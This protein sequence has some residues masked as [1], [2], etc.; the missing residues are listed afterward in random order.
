PQSLSVLLL[1]FL[2]SCSS[3]LPASLPTL[4]PY[5]TLFRSLADLAEHVFGRH[6]DVLEDQ[7]RRRRAVQ[8][9]LV[10]F[11]A[12]LHAERALDEER[13]ELLAVDLRKD[14]E[15]IG[16]AAV[17]DPHL[18]AVDHEAAVRLAHGLGE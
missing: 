7:R 16:E 17:G 5:T 15:Q 13:G 11:L 9:H 8:T 1:F 3:L 10:L 2:S 4:F 14:D 18:L 12:A 6:L